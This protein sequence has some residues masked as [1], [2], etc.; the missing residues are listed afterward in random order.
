[1]QWIELAC[2]ALGSNRLFESVECQGC[3]AP[4]D[5]ALVCSHC[6]AAAWCSEECCRNTIDECHPEELCR[7][8][9]ASVLWIRRCSDLCAYK[10]QLASRVVC[11]AGASTIFRRMAD[12][13]AASGLP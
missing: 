1:M 13:A 12:L 7:D 3:G 10:Q 8:L 11:A 2:N 5:H 9:C 6:K 4:V